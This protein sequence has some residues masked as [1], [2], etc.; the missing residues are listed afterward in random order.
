MLHCCLIVFSLGICAAIW[1]RTAN[2]LLL[3]VVWLSF[4]HI[5]EA[6]LWHLALPRDPDKSN[7]VLLALQLFLT[8]ARSHLPSVVTFFL[9]TLVYKFG[10]TANAIRMA[11]LAEFWD[12]WNDKTTRIAFV[13]L[14]TIYPL[15]GSMMKYLMKASIFRFATGKFKLSIPFVVRCGF[16]FVFESDSLTVLSRLH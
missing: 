16:I 3:T 1:I 5:L 2:T 10:N 12:S 7:S 8:G 15:V 6:W 13:A 4:W 11:N 9:A 14:T